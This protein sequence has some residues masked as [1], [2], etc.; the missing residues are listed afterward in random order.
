MEKLF[1]EIE[2]LI[3]E[4]SEYRP[5]TEGERH[6]LNEQFMIESTYHSNAIGGNTMTL[7]ETYIVIKENVVLSHKTLKEHLEV[8]GHKEAFEY[9]SDMVSK[10]EPITEQAIKDIHSIVLMDSPRNRGKYR[11]VGV[12]VGDFT[13]M[14]AGFVPE[15][16][17]K[18]LEDYNSKSTAHPIEKIADFHIKFERILPFIKGNGQTG[19]L[20]INLEL[21]K[22][23][24]MPISIKVDDRYEYYACF[25]DFEENGTSEKFTKMVAGYEIEQLK[26]RLRILKTALKCEQT[27]GWN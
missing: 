12:K 26:E 24:Y 23:G 10:K 9:V 22:A 3:K 8:I 5:L 18:L 21:M 19:R 2:N 17:T 7:D 15:H 11:K 13:P 6:R 4:L 16:M 14:D 1:T 20:L 27:W 25:K